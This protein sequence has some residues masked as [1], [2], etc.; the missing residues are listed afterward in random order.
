MADGFRRMDGADE[1][2]IGS[3]SDLI[4]LVVKASRRWHW[5]P[6][7]WVSPMIGSTFAS[8]T[9]SRTSRHY[10]AAFAVP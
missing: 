10:P 2:F 6:S 5:T 8:G 3:A 9:G 1:G 4:W 7:N